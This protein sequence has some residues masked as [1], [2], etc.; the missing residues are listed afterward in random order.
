MITDIVYSTN[1]FVLE[2]PNGTLGGV[3]KSYS[4]DGLNYDFTESIGGGGETSSVFV[5]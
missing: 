4:L 3:I 1:E 2:M 5:T